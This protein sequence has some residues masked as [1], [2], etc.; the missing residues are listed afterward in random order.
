MNC[1]YCTGGNGDILIYRFYFCVRAMFFDTE[2]HSGFTPSV[3]IISLVVRRGTVVSLLV[4]AVAERGRFSTNRFRPHPV[5]H[6]FVRF[7][8]PRGGH[9]S[10]TGAVFRT[11]HT[12][13]RIPTP[14]ER[15]VFGFHR[16]PVSKP[17]DRCV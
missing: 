8:G 5:Q 3:W 6:A 13:R 16:K 17:V 4:N 1:R 9:D 14:D 12:L 2:I 10:R 15:V 7:L 11:R